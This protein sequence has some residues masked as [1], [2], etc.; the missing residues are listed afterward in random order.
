MIVREAYRDR[1][2]RV[3]QRHYDSPPPGAPALGPVEDARDSG[4]AFCADRKVVARVLADCAL[5]ILSS[6]TDPVLAPRPIVILVGD[7]DGYP[8][9]VTVDRG[10]GGVSVRLDGATYDAAESDL[11]APAREK[12]RSILR[13]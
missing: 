1:V 5:E 8:V 6:S 12:L 13:G 9:R 10:T 7:D 4:C 2:V 11:P 3:C